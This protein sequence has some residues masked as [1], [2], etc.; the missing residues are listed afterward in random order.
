MQTKEVVGADWVSIGPKYQK[1]PDCNGKG[2]I[3][4]QGVYED[5]NDFMECGRCESA[6]II[7]VEPF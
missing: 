6:G 4:I 2:H 1:C 5:E 3:E 7:E